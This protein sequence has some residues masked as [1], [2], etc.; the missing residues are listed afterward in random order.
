MAPRPA[1]GR[2][3]PENGL[4][5]QD[6]PVPLRGAD[7]AAASEP[8]R[9]W[10]NLQ[11]FWNEQ[12]SPGLYSWWEG[13]GEENTFHLWEAVRGWVKPPCVTPHYWTGG[14]ILALQVEMLAYV[15]ESGTE[16]VL[17]VGGGVPQSWVGQAMRVSAL[18]T[19]AGLVDWSWKCAWG[20][21]LA[22]QSGSRQPR[23]SQ[24]CAPNPHGTI[25]L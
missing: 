10:E 13:T 17:V 14:E 19:S 15:D 5:R 8:K 18:P 23:P 6:P 2:A 25:D 24:C 1:Q 16:P 3:R 11:W 7:C 21:R 9:V 22:P 12:T 20:R 4:D